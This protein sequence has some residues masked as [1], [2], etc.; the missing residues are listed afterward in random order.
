MGASERHKH[1]LDDALFRRIDI[2]SLLVFRMCFGLILLWE[3]LRYL[4]NGWIQETWL[5]PPYL[6]K[7]YGFEWLHPWPGEGMVYHFIALAV[8]ALCITLGFFY[9][10]C[11]TLYWLGFTYV[12]LLD[13]A[14]YLNHLY[15][16]CLLCFLMIFVPA[17]AGWSVDA[18][19]WPRNRKDQVPAWTLWMLRAQI[20]LVYFFAGLAK[21]N[22]DWLS[23]MPTRIW[24]E[25]YT[26]I[27]ILGILAT[28]DLGVYAFGCGGLLF[29]LLIA[30]LLLWRRSRAVAVVLALGF[31]LINASMHWI[32]IFPWLMIAATALFF[33]P[34]WPRH[35]LP[36]EAR[37]PE[38]E[39]TTQ[40]QRLKRVLIATCLAVFFAV[41]ILLPLRHFAYPGNA[42]WTE[43]GHRF[44]WRMKLRIKTGTI[45]FRVYNPPSD[46][47]WTVYPSEFFDAYQIKKLVTR[48]DMIIQAAHYIADD[49]DAIGFPDVEVRADALVSLHKRPSQPLVDPNT[50]LAAEP[51][52]LRHSKWIQPLSE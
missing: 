42:L 22:S 12:F 9:R 21:V 14:V 6:F 32:G 8:L 43:E 27:P 2:A 29:D 15:L 45:V 18:W 28:S 20:G 46:Q 37:S 47:E 11:M 48:P 26:N 50:D 52:T 34:D 25:R 3:T 33:E 17:S 7:Y 39:P 49:F 41:Q 19:L 23:G 40:P 24:L 31:H 30:P 38:A 44:A 13:Q 51:R 1:R 36:Q 4:L 16:V 35:S 5:A 10:S